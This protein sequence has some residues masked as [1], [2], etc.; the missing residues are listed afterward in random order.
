MLNTMHAPPFSTNYINNSDIVDF[1]MSVLLQ[2]AN[3][4]F[5]CHRP[6]WFYRHN[7]AHGMNTVEKVQAARCSQDEQQPL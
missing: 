2:A 5:P 7:I 4:L 1:I 3:P 6:P